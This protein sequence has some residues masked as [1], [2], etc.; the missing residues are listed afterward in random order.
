MCPLKC[1]WLTTVPSQSCSRSRCLEQRSHGPRLP[2]LDG[3]HMM[4]AGVL[5]KSTLEPHCN[6]HKKEPPTASQADSWTHYRGGE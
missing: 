5:G 4:H 2:M 6:Y 1:P 3:L